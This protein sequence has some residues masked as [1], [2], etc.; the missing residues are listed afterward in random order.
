MDSDGDL[1]MAG[2]R[3]NQATFTQ[4]TLHVITWL[5]TSIYIDEMCAGYWKIL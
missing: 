3:E 1:K 5:D 4:S 2:K